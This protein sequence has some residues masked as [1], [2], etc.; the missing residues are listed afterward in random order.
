MDRLKNNRNP[1]ALQ[2]AL[3]A[4]C[5]NSPM[6]LRDKC[7]DLVKDHADEII[8][9]INQDDEGQICRQLYMCW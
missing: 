4:A 5:D 1:Q 2:E 6:V 8:N 9:L 7:N 3:N